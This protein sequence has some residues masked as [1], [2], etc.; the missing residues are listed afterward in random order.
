MSRRQSHSLQVLQ[1]KC[2]VWR[3]TAMGQFRPWCSIGG[4]DSFPLDSLRGGETSAREGVGQQ[5]TFCEFCGLCS[6]TI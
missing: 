6:R 4:D 5:G 1:R 3:R 2:G